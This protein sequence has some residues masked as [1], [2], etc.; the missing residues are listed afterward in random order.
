MGKTTYSR[1]PS[2]SKGNTRVIQSP[3]AQVEISESTS[4]IHTKQPMPSKVS[5][6]PKPNNIS[7]M[8]SPTEDVS[9]T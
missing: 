8:S 2:T 6:S 3:K 5:P 7:R 9:H 4:R 1:A